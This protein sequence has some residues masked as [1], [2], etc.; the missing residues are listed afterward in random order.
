[1]SDLIGW[2]AVT[3]PAWKPTFEQARFGLETRFTGEC[4]RCKHDTF[5]RVPFSKPNLQGHVKRGETE[6]FTMICRCGHPHPGHPEGDNSC[7]AYWSY[8]IEV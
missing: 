4:P 2:A 5:L 3:D 7:G 6:P 8:E 1:M